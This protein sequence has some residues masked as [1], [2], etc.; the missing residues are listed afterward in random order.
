MKIS[1]HL[2]HNRS[3]AHGVD[4]SYLS[5]IGTQPLGKSETCLHVLHTTC[6]IV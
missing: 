6:H 4:F 2:L 1:R 3:I 5:S